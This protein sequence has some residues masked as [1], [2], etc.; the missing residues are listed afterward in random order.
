MAVRL[1][2]SLGSCPCLSCWRGPARM[3]TASRGDRVSTDSVRSSPEQSG[4]PPLCKALAAH[5]SVGEVNDELVPTPSRD[6][7]G[8][9]LGGF[10]G[11]ACAGLH[12][13]VVPP[14]A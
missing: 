10:S 5:S 1:R 8:D 11:A 2:A 6:R 12:P 4:G 3:S 9:H 13:L 14:S 7:L